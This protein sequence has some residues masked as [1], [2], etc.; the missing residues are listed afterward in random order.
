MVPSLREVLD[1]PGVEAAFVTKMASEH[2]ECTRQLLRAGKHVLVEKPF[3][4]RSK[5]ATELTELA[6]ATGRTLAVG[7]EFM[8]APPL[9]RLR[10]A[11]EQ[12][13]P[14][15]NRVTFAWEDCR[16]TVKYGV[17]KEPDC[18]SP[19]RSTRTRHHRGARSWSRR[20]QDAPFVSTSRTSPTRSIW[21]GVRFLPMA[22]PMPFPDR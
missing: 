22:R 21:T 20:R 16:N 6:A 2:Y 1:S 11:I 8:F 17:R 3:V 12:H 10:D 4:L 18:T 9:H 5:E 19:C 7:Y 13:L 14:D 15:A